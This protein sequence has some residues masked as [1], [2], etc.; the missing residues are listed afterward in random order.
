MFSLESCCGMEP[1]SRQANSSPSGARRVHQAGEVGAEASWEGAF[2]I[3]ND[4]WISSAPGLSRSTFLRAEALQVARGRRSSCELAG[5][6]LG[7]NL[8]W[9]PSSPT[10]TLSVSGAAERP[11]EAQRRGVRRRNRDTEIQ[12]EIKRGRLV[13][14]QGQRQATSQTARLKKT[15]S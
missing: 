14:T 15:R 3:R 9:L 12:R 2:S 7:W 8:V 13:W 1:S 5:G 4:K 11:K 10:Q 6:G